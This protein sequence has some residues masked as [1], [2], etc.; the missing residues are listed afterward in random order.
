MNGGRLH[1]MK[2]HC[3]K[4]RLR[5]VLKAYRVIIAITNDMARGLRVLVNLWWGGFGM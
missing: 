3:G 2:K 4:N 1:E 5:E